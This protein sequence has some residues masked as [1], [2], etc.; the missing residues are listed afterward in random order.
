MGRVIEW[1]KD[2]DESVDI[3]QKRAVL[4]QLRVWSEAAVKPVVLEKIV[5]RAIKVDI[6]CEMTGNKE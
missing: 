6:Y 5:R 1:D 3:L 4:L 2:E